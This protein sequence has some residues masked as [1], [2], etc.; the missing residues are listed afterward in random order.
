MIKYNLQIKR[1]LSSQ[2][3][4]NNDLKVENFIKSTKTNS[5]TSSSGGIK[6]PPICSA[7]IFIET[8]PNNHGLERVVVSFERTDITQISIIT[9][10]N[11][12]FSI[13]TSHSLKSMCRFRIQL[14]LEDITGNTENTI[15]KNDSSTDWT[16]LNLVSTVEKYGIKLV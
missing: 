5:P 9:F 3:I 8:S 6:L 13:L 10:R 7:L 1:K 4:K 2:T 12:R 15:P 16:L 14:F 11:N